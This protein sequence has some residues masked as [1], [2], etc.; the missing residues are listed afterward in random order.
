MIPLGFMVFS[1]ERPHCRKPKHRSI[2]DFRMALLT[3][4]LICGIYRVIHPQA[5]HPC[6]QLWES[7]GRSATRRRQCALLAWPS[8][9][10]VSLSSRSS[11][12]ALRF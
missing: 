3:F 2:R 11:S 12:A 5:A 7:R 4:S 9:P 10:W 6:P 8:S 1:R